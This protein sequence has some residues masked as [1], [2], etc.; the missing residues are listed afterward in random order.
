MVGWQA[1][2]RLPSPTSPSTH[3]HC[4]F[5]SSYLV[6]CR[7]GRKRKNPKEYRRRKRKGYKKLER[8]ERRVVLRMLQNLRR[9][10]KQT[11]PSSLDHGSMG[12]KTWCCP[13]QGYNRALCGQKERNGAGAGSWFQ[14]P[15]SPFCTQIKNKYP[16]SV[17]TEYGGICLRMSHVGVWGRRTAVN[18]M[19]Y[20]AT[21]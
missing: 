2:Q 17:V 9:R 12:L 19:P 6:P 1:T 15:S 3:K 14:R 13:A 16:W 4:Q 20:W 11:L 8:K 10:K 18:S 21:S 7:K 5:Q